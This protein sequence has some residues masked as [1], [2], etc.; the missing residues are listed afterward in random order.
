MITST[1]NPQIK[2][3]RKLKERKERLASGLYYLEG[4][5]IVYE[6]IQRGVDLDKII[7]APELAISKAAHD[8]KSKADQK[9]IPILEVNADVF[10][11]MSLKE[12]PQGVAAVGH[13]QWATLDA[14]NPQQGDL[15]V[16]LDSVADPGNLGTILRTCDA[17]GGRGI[18]LLDQ[19]TDPYDPTSIRASMGA[20]F[21]QT[22]VKTDFSTFSLWKQKCSVTVIGTSD[23]AK[24]DYHH[25][26]YPDPII[27]LMGSERNGLLD[28]HYQICS[29]V[30]RIPMLGHSDSLNLSVATAVVLYEILNQRRAD[31]IHHSG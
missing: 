20:L 30:V 5:R 3:I 11:S 19:S 6:A 24:V 8:I 31:D 16:A 10:R 4:L 25:I 22:L 23:S 27:L 9:N 21:S 7:I 13:Q 18:I 1:S 17:V 15:W 2:A 12:G 14:I 28:K 29:Q 26:Q